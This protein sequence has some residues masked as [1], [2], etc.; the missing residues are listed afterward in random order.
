MEETERSVSFQET[1]GMQREAVGSPYV[2]QNAAET[3]LESRNQLYRCLTYPFMNKTEIVILHVLL[4]LLTI[5][6]ILFY[7]FFG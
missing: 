2:S 5:F 7:S 1:I 4:Q 6:V 3:L